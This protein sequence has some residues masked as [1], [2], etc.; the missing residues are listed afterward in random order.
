MCLWYLFVTLL[1]LHV[2]S[3]NGCDLDVHIVDWQMSKKTE[4]SKMSVPTPFSNVPLQG[5]VVSHESVLTGAVGG[6][7]VQSGARARTMTEKGLIWQLETQK[8]NFQSSISAWRRRAGRKQWQGE[9]KSTLSNTG[10]QRLAQIQG[11]T[12]CTLHNCGSKLFEITLYVLHSFTP[13]TPALILIIYVYKLVYFLNNILYKN[14]SL[15]T[16][17]ISMKLYKEN[18]T[19]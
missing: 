15:L 18:P 2:N 4:L 5:N 1:L 11:I 9:D 3:A 17:L 7:T 12:G 14:T 8:E 10:P 6:A 16:I 13:P 19:S